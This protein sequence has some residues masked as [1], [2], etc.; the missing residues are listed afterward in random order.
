[1]DKLLNLLYTSLSLINYNINMITT[2][3]YAILSVTAISL[4]SLI[5]IFAL[6]LKEENLKKFLTYMVS[7]STGALFG[8]AFFHLLPEI[9]NNIGFTPLVSTYVL[10]GVLFSFVVEK[11]VHW[12]HCHNPKHIH[13]KVHTFAYMNLFGDGIHNF[14]DGLIIGASYLINIPTGIATTIAVILH[15]I[16]QEI[17]DFGVLLQGGFNRKKALFFNFLTALTA[18]VGVI[19]ALIIGSYSEHMTVFLVPFAAGSFIYIAGADLIPELH[20]EKNTRKSFWQLI[21]LIL[22]ILVIASMLLMP[23][24]HSHSEEIHDD[25]KHDHSQTEHEH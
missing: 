10:S 19:I 12:R 8:G 18:L 22:G 15:E 23:H 1:V 7:F 25:N 16:P 3:V 6:Y 5:A 4:I 20:K 9:T 21:S 13:E 17:G 2:W 14:I 24:S 11:F